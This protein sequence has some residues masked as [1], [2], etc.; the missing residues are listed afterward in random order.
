MPELVQKAIILLKSI[1][2]SGFKYKKAGVML[3]DIRPKTDVQPDLF[4][5]ESSDKKDAVINQKWKMR[6]EHLS[7]RFITS[8]QDILKIKI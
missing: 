6:R 7:N 4:E 8:W 5:Y 2:R 3:T 1:Y